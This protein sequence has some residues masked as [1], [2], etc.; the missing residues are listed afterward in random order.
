MNDRLICLVPLLTFWVNGAM[1]FIARR[2]LSLPALQFVATTHYYAS[3]RLSNDK[4]RRT[5]S[6]TQ[7][8]F[9]G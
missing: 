2:L 8:R 5:L 3:L 4:M 6:N 7:L 1:T 9:L